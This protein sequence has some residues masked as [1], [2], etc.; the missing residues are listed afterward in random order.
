MPL[1]ED[2]VGEFRVGQRAGEL[3]GADHQRVDTERLR[4]R[5]L[6]IVRRQYG[7]DVVDEREHTVGIGLLGRGRAAPDL[8]EER[9]RRAA[10]FRFVAV[11]GRQILTHDPLDPRPVGCH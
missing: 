5:R 11:S 6:G 3:Q 7:G 2:L 1:I 8:I 4:P 10:F 9:S